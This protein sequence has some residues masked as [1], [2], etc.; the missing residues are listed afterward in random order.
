MHRLRLRARLAAAHDLRPASGSYQ[1]PL[2]RARPERRIHI[3]AVP[4]ALHEKSAPRLLRTRGAAAMQHALIR[5]RP[6]PTP[7]PGRAVRPGER[8]RR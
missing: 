3:G 7:L 4:A 2:T 1:L 8:R 6:D 5:P